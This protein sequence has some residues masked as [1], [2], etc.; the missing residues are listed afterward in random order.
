MGHEAGGHYPGGLG[1]SDVK[2]ATGVMDPRRCQRAD[3]DGLYVG[4]GGTLGALLGVVADLR[5]FGE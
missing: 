5:A 2:K 1:L 4:G 3:L